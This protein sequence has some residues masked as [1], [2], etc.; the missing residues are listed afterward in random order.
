MWWWMFVFGRLNIF[1]LLKSG[2]T[3]TCCGSAVLL[4]QSEW[5]IALH[6]LPFVAVANWHQDIFLKSNSSKNNH[7]C[8]TG[9]HHSRLNTVF[10]IWSMLNM[11]IHQMTNIQHNAALPVFQNSSASS[12]SF[13][14]FS[15]IADCLSPA[16][17][18][19]GTHLLL[20]AYLNR[21]VT[22]D[23][24]LQFSV[25]PW[26]KWCSPKQCLYMQTNNSESTT[27]NG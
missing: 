4:K 12:E 22:P 21:L 24:L 10:D 17:H 18:Y 13:P 6:A 20:N 15:R 16:L 5:N 7:G 14:F 1:W 23:L 25:R 9:S 8:F 19:W 27:P 2:Y 11:C 3:P 26:C